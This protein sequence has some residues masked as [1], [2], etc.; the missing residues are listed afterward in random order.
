MPTE[1]EVA[2]LSDAPAERLLAVEAKLVPFCQIAKVHARL[3]VLAFLKKRSWEQVSSKLQCLAE[4][5]SVLTRSAHVKKF[6]R[7][8]LVLGNYVNHSLEMNTGDSNW[9]AEKETEVVWGIS[10]ESL[11]KLSDYK[12]NNEKTLLHGIAACDGELLPKIKI[13]LDHWM[14][15]I[16]TKKLGKPVLVDIVADLQT[17]LRE[18]EFVK[19]FS[20]YGKKPTPTESQDRLNI[21][22]SPLL[23]DARDQI[24]DLEEGVLTKQRGYLSSVVD[25][26]AHLGCQGPYYATAQSKCQMK[27]IFQDNKVLSQS[28]KLVN[29]MSEQV[30]NIF[31]VFHELAFFFT[32]KLA[33]EEKQAKALQKQNE[34]AEFMRSLKRE[35]SVRPST[36]NFSSSSSGQNPGASRGAFAPAS[37]V[38][39]S[40]GGA[41]GRASTGSTT[42][43]SNSRSSNNIGGGITA[44]TGSTSGSSSRPPTATTADHQGKNSLAGRES[45]DSSSS[46]MKSLR[47]SADNKQLVSPEKRNSAASVRARSSA[48]FN[49]AN[50]VTDRRV[51]RA[52]SSDSEG[53]S[54]RERRMS[55]KR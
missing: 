5:S 20:F 49:P 44:V 53:S 48:K 7:L 17:L 11:Q 19:T 16:W 1:A 28:G 33:E 25:L 39:S 2:V 6:L 55:G 15:E 54:D 41:G 3:R 26:C 31:S 37:R 32:D 52:S 12:G 51:R 47:R 42:E 22:S 40:G 23:E 9:L 29:E 24:K 34:A 13:E 8:L 46:L 38:S 50:R 36:R 45:V 10:V 35:S 21:Y 4:I 27:E 14:S 18:I 30:G 43:A